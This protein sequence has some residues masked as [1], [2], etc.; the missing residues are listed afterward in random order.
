MT[1][2]IFS[3]EK[4]LKALMNI[5]E[6]SDTIKENLFQR[7]GVSYK[8]NSVVTL[9]V[10]SENSFDGF[11]MMI[12]LAEECEKY[13]GKEIEISKIKIVVFTSF[14]AAMKSPHL[15]HAKFIIMPKE[16]L[17]RAI[18]YPELEKILPFKN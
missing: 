16:N 3:N 6:I 11:D 7:L 12:T 5:Q 2:Y 8:K 15:E 10:I 13:Y 1:H 4:Y 14:D 18:Y 17:T 9:M